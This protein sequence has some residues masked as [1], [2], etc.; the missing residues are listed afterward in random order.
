MALGNNNNWTTNNIKF[1]RINESGH[2]KIPT[3]KLTSIKIQIDIH[4]Q[5][6]TTHK[7]SVFLTIWIELIRVVTNLCP[8][9]SFQSQPPALLSSSSR[10]RSCTCTYVQWAVLSKNNVSCS[11]FFVSETFAPKVGTLPFHRPHTRQTR[12]IILIALQTR[13]TDLNLSGPSSV[14]TSV[15]VQ[16]SKH[17]WNQNLLVSLDPTCNHKTL[18]RMLLLTDWLCSVAGG[19]EWTAAL[20]F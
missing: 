7:S 4:Y 8:I 6:L 15:S 9:A 16:A 5:S 1:T 2:G 12:T 17:A 11:G 13:V 3:H 14:F 19:L 10:F 18:Q 20:L